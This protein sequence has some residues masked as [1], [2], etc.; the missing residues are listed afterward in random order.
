MVFVAA[1][2][3]AAQGL[4][5]GFRWLDWFFGAV[6][7]SAVLLVIVACWNA[8]RVARR[9]RRTMGRLEAIDPEAVARQ[10]VNEERQRL[11]HDI[12]ACLHDSLAAIAR[13]AGA[14]DATADPRPVLVRIQGE[15]NWATTELRRQLGLLRAEDTAALSW[16]SR[17][18]T[19][20]GVRRGDVV[21]ALSTLLLGA[22]DLLIFG[23]IEG[24]QQTLLTV[25][26]TLA[27]PA[28]VVWSRVAP[29]GSAVGL[30]G[31]LALGAIIDQ[32]VQ[33]GFALALASGVLVWCCAAS[34]T[35][36]AWLT[37]LVLIGTFLVSRLVNH[38]ENAPVGMA[39]V[40]LALV[41]GATVG[42]S[43]R[44]RERAEISAGA[45]R[46]MIRT[47]V[48]EA[49]GA[50]RRTVARE[51]HDVVSHAVSVIAVQAGAAELS[52]PADPIAADRAIGFV[53]TT[54]EQTV[55]ELGR[56]K[57]GVGSIRHDVNDLRLLV[58]R[59]HA[60]R[61]SV[62]LEVSGAPRAELPSTIY[63]VVQE[64]LTNA[65]R[66]APNSRVLV[67][68]EW[69]SDRI[70]VQVIDD[71]PGSMQGSRRGYGLIGLSERL[72]QAG[73]TLVIRSAPEVAG[74]EVAAVL[75]THV[76]GAS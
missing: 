7:Y 18:E 57:P 37:V 45:R 70:E 29:L 39:L 51:L 76:I 64:S 52:W 9:E 35:P 15:A 2:I 68:I 71:G 47:A 53:R 61:L 25:L 72:K 50:E 3:S 13:D 4:A 44:R 42:R 32:P 26:L 30:A 74:F 54:A 75:P 63:R 1:A 65:L 62:T 34:A 14:I 36:R 48:D 28:P 73:G 56:L 21:L 20:P 55:A 23:R 38:P 67:K 5:E 46:R 33:D 43:R 66:Y 41:G 27:L 19:G 60:A 11:S 16:V 17:S 58:N 8:V 59:M 40:V 12:E 10:A 22:A 6:V 69:R 31:L 49:V 24:V